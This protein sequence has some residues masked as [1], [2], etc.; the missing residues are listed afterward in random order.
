MTPEQ[1]IKAIKAELVRLGCNQ[2]TISLSIDYLNKFPEFLTYDFSVREFI[3][4]AAGPNPI[5]NIESIVKHHDAFMRFGYTYSDIARF[6]SLQTG[7]TRLE[8]MLKFQELLQYLGFTNE[9]ILSILERNTGV[10]NLY[11]LIAYYD[12]LQKIGFGIK[13]MVSIGQQHYG[14]R[15]VAKIEANIETLFGFD[16]DDIIRYTMHK[17]ARPIDLEL[18]DPP[19]E[20]SRI[21]EKRANALIDEFNQ[22]KCLSTI[23]ALSRHNPVDSTVVDIVHS[24]PI[25]NDAAS[26]PKTDFD[27]TAQ[28][29]DVDVLMQQPVPELFSNVITQSQT[30]FTKDEILQSTDLHD[31]KDQI[32]KILRESSFSESYAKKHVEKISPY[33]IRL[34]NLSISINKIVEISKLKNLEEVASRLINRMTKYLSQGYS[35]SQILDLA[36]KS[37]GHVTLDIL[38][39]YHVKLINDFGFIHKQILMMANHTCGHKNL[40]AVYNNYDRLVNEFHLTNDDIIAIVSRHNGYEN[41]E[42][43]IDCYNLLIGLNY[44]HEQIVDLANKLN[45]RSVFNTVLAYHFQLTIDGVSQAHIIDILCENNGIQYLSIL[46]YHLL[47]RKHHPSDVHALVQTILNHKFEQLTDQVLP[48][49]Y[50]EL[51]LRMATQKRKELKCKTVPAVVTSS[52]QQN[53]CQTTSKTVPYLTN[54]TTTSKTSTQSGKKQPIGVVTDTLQQQK[55]IKSTQPLQSTEQHAMKTSWHNAASLVVDKTRSTLSQQQAR[56]VPTSIAP[57]PGQASFGLFAL[58]EQPHVISCHE[59]SVSRQTQ[60]YVVE[61]EVLTTQPANV[62]FITNSHTL[63]TEQSEI[64]IDKFIALPLESDW[65]ELISKVQSEENKSKPSV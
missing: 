51:I 49:N 58:P 19:I 39:D 1:K 15:T 48:S 25:V 2:G 20:Y 41:I 45:A 30:Q 63:S 60:T 7:Y 38:Q 24:S 65:D 16:I 21:I 6:G 40:L 27:I 34:C 23:P 64:D 13:D 9:N 57:R 54:V 61:K 14:P 8:T 62:Q 46:Y 36:I 31:V 35:Q 10:S 17:N 18:I 22:K 53:F 43:F 33:L 56:K 11:A 55:R 4:I 52:Q 50:L 28:A 42:A 12:T 5:A 26:H 44:T 3:A 59:E 32:Y 29:F 37:N 47:K